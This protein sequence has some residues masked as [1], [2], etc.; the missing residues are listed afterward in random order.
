MR[1]NVKH[2]YRRADRVEAVTPGI[3]TTVA[4]LRS[5][6]RL[7]VFWRGSVCSKCAGFRVRH[8]TGG[9]AVGVRGGLRTLNVDPG[10]RKSL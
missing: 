9:G 3:L 6:P 4:S 7:P 5:V 10:K 2:F 1:V 8:E